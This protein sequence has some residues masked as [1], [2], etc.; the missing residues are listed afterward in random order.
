MAEVR[1]LD[2]GRDGAEAET[3][4]TLDEVLDAFGQ[5][6]PF[7]LEIK[8]GEGGDYA[9]LEAQTLAAVEK[10]GLLSRTLF[11]SF[12]DSVLA[13]LRRLS[14][15]ARL[16]VLV[17]PRRAERIFER[18][19]AVGAEAVN[20][21]HVLAQPQFIEEAHAAGLSV[22]PYTVDDEARMDLLVGWGVD[23]LFTNRPDAMRALLH[24]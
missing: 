1:E 5:R 19:E 6:I 9:G 24:L 8:W 17:D 16:A 10:R 20:P 4:P 7:N 21:H 3:V 18:T 11:S 15:D 14:P 23:G 13:E 12:R 22:F 2:I